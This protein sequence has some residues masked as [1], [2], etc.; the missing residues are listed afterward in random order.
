MTRQLA[1]LVI[2]SLL[3]ARSL[4]AQASAPLPQDQLVAKLAATLDSLTAA[5]QFSGAVALDRAGERVFDRAYGVAD[6]ATKRQNTLQAEFNIGSINKVFT[7]IAIRQL[8]AAGKLDLDS[9]LGHYW[10]EYPNP[11]ARRATIRQLLDHQAGLGGNIFD[12]PSGGARHDVTHNRDYLQLFVNEPQAFE[13]GTSRRY[14][15]ACYVVLGILIEKLSGE[16]YYEYVERHIYAPAGMTHTAWYMA[17]SL[18][19]NAAI[20]YT[21]GEDED[22][23]PGAPLAPNT[24]ML[25]G[26]G[27]AAGGGYSTVGDLL[28]F[29][30]ALRAGKIPSGPAP[31]IGIAGGAP[32]LNAALEGELPGGYNVAVA[33]NLDPPAAER[34]AELVRNWLGVSDGPGP[35]PGP[36]PASG[37]GTAPHP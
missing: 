3:A 14:C 13:P 37:P 33:S 12:A 35:G 19:P 16:D 29:L 17:D 5:G 30:D 20:G 21:R 34:I 9:S 32:G 8:A 26:R 11:T 25:P 15:N 18:P 1:V 28:L 23:P 27:S 4:D 6:R 24:A 10:P 31:G 36:R 7:A 2:A 22:A